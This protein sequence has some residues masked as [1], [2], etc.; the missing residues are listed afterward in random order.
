MSQTA[1]TGTAVTYTYFYLF[2]ALGK[3]SRLRARLQG[4][5]VG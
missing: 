2:G 4:D 5:G 1:S 3:N